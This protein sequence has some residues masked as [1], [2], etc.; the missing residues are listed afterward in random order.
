MD[1]NNCEYSM[2]EA[3]TISE[4]EVLAVTLDD[5]GGDGGNNDGFVNVTVTGGTPDYVYTWSDG[6]GFTSGDEDL[7]G[8]GVGTYT[9][10][11][12]D[13]N[14]CSV[15]MTASATITGINEI[16]DGVSFT[17]NPNP[18][19][20]KFFLNVQGLSGQKL[21]YKVLDTTGRLIASKELG[22]NSGNRMEQV[23]V[24]GV[25]AGVYYVQLIVG[26]NVG[27]IKLVKN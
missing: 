14:G 17:I 25:A 24:T 1:S 10:S 20:G 6:Q 4:P 27:T 5:F 19:N 3:A 15:D 23:D 13:A 12:T 9:L 11:V 8:V 26:E 18:T 22:N 2:M 16:V 7:A 21:T